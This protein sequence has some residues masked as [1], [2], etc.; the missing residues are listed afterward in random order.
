M[1][2]LV[3]PFGLYRPVNTPWHFAD[4]TTGA[5]SV[6]SAHNRA[7]PAGEPLDP[8]EWN[9]IGDS[10]LVAPFAS[11][12]RVVTSFTMEFDVAAR[13]SIFLSP[14]GGW[15]PSWAVA[16]LGF[17]PVIRTEGMGDVTVPGCEVRIPVT[18]WL[19][20]DSVRGRQAHMFICEHSWKPRATGAWWNVAV[21]MECAAFAA[22]SG[23]SQVSG[24]TVIERIYYEVT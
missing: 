19:G 21:G 6:A 11:R 15:A 17:R 10:V 20:G 24:R 16:I 12:I 23:S 13:A 22:G 8:V 9:Y 5:M 18:A 3:P 1:P 14:L 7:S 4:P 2:S